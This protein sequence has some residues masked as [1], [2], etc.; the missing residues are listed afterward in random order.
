MDAAGRGNGPLPATADRHHHSV[1]KRVPVVTEFL[2]PLPAPLCFAC[3][4]CRSPVPAA[5][6]PRVLEPQRGGV[7]GRAVAGGLGCRGQL[8]YHAQVRHTCW[9]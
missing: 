6:P 9:C 4:A 3:S 5:Q 1:Q 2:Y 7:Q 8:E